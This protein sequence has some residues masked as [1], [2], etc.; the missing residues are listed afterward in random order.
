M[1]DEE[2][3]GPHL[4]LERINEE[5]K[6]AVLSDLHEREGDAPLVKTFIAVTRAVDPGHHSK[7]RVVFTGDFIGSVQDREDTGREYT[8]ERGAGMVAAKTMPPN[9]E[10]FVDVLIPVFW[11]LPLDDADQE[12]ERH[13]LIA[14]VAAHEAVHASIHHLEVDPFEVYKR[15]ELGHATL[16]YMGMAGEQ[17]EEYLAEYLS[18]QVVPSSPQATADQVTASFEAFEKTLNEK[19]PAIGETDP[20]RYRKAMEVTF[21]ALHIFWKAL[22]YMAA[23]LRQPDGTFAAVPEGVA[24]LSVWT[25]SVAPWW[26]EYTTLLGRIPMSV[27]P[28]IEVVEGAVVEIAAQLQRWAYGI[29]F[30]F[31]DTDDGGYFRIM[32]WD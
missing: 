13:Q 8:V 27:D 16:Q 19:L 1:S 15:R 14:H 9:D 3:A 24:G 10:G 30:D 7:T 11:V 18:S 31:H 32:L 22:A 23:E 26:E 4:V 21:E 17:A 29:G 12:A 28:D 6:N 25:S 2:E 5:Q 20:D